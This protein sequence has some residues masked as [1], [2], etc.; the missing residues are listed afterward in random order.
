MTAL[1]TVCCQMLDGA[2]LWQLTVIV[3]VC[4]DAPQSR[5]PRYR[6]PSHQTWV[7]FNPYIYLFVNLRVLVYIN[8]FLAMQARPF[9]TAS[10]L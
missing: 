9:P 6:V 10:L 1:I 4:G 3:L 8:S 7:R 2:F 5:F